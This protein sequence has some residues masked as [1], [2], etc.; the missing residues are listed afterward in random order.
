MSEL[1][2]TACTSLCVLLDYNSAN[3]ARA[4][5]A[6]ALPLVQAAA[7]RTDRGALYV[8]LDEYVGTIVEHIR[9]FEAGARAAADAA[10]AALLAEEEAERAAPH[11]ATR[12]SKKKRNKHKKE[13]HAAADGS[14][15]HA[16]AAAAAEEEEPAAAPPPEEQPRPMCAICL[17]A[18]PCVVL[19]PCRHVP[20]CAAPACAAMLGAPPLC[21]LC[22]VAVT[23][24][25]QVYP[26]SVKHPLCTSEHISSQAEVRKTANCMRLCIYM[27]RA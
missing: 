10:A 23:D 9:K 24:T 5:R 19:L 8:H 7:A 12:K 15:A 21:P 11:A 6:G 18:L 17:D 4:W 2:F 1:Q 14:A 13:A 3:V 16:S 27:A 26:L 20:L 25:M 22:R